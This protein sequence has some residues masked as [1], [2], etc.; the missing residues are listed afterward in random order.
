MRS[1]FLLLV[2]LWIALRLNAQVVSGRVVDATGGKP[3]EYVSIGVVNTTSGTITNEQGKFTFAV[4]GLSTDAEVRFSMIGFKSRTFTIEELAG[5]DNLIRLTGEP[6]QLKEVV[7][8]PSGKFRKVGTTSYTFHGG[9]AGWGG[10]DFGKG[11]EIGSRIDLGKLPVKI[12]SL[13]IRISKQSF[14]SSLFRIHIRD[15]KDNMPDHELL[16]KNII[17]SL[18]KES[19]WEDIDL[20]KY[21]L[22]YS[23]EIAFSLEWVKVRGLNKNKMM[24]MNG[25]KNY[26]AIVLFTNKKNQGCSYTR[27]GTEAKWNRIDT[28]SPSFYLTIEE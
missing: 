3:L 26:S 28:E 10:N 24:K 9:L 1:G 11:Y 25:N 27:W 5:K 13:H 20:G 21:N 19:G 2:F 15:L 14:D 16:N 17:I 6:I 7:I 4:K 18:I 12:K 8:K 23:G 22:V